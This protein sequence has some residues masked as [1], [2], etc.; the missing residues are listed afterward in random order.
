MV[1]GFFFIKEIG[2]VRTKRCE[3]NIFT[4]TIPYSFSIFA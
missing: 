4:D 1:T 3:F 2:F